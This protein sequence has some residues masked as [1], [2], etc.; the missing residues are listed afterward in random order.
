MTQPELEEVVLALR[1]ADL[2]AEPLSD[3]QVGLLQKELRHARTN[4]M[5]HEKDMENMLREG[6]AR[7]AVVRDE[8]SK[9]ET[10]CSELRESAKQLETAHSDDLVKPL[11]TRSSE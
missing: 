7:D 11:F 6:E 1:S 9:L 2:G 4:L 10:V 3:Q 5:I 8:L